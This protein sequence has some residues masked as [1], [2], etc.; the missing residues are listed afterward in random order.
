M[1]SPLPSSALLS[2]L[3]LAGCT[4]GPRFT[5]PHSDTPAGWSA[6]ALAAVPGRAPGSPVAATPITE[7]EWWRSFGDPTLSSLIEQAA[8][9]SLDVREAVLRIAEAR[10]QRD[11]TAAGLWPDLSGNASYVRERISEKMAFTSL[12]GSAGSTTP[13]RPPQGGISG[14]IPGF[15][16]P[17]SAYQYGFDA[18]WELDLFGRTR[19]AVEAAG[20]D[21]DAALESGRDVLLSVLAEIARSYVD[22]RAA[23]LRL[24][25]LEDSLRTE[26]DTLQL[27]R[28]RRT[29]GL[30][31][32]LDVERAAAQVTSTESQLPLAR[33]RITTDINQ[34]SFLLGREP[35]ALRAE[36]ERTAP[37]PAVPP[38]V[39]IGLPAEVIRRRPDIRLAEAQLHAATARVGVAVADL[40]PR[41]TLNA[42]VG[43]QAEHPQD[44]TNWASR[45]FSVGPA[46]ELPIFSGG[47]RQATV[48]L[49]NVRT[50]E[51]AVAYARTV[52]AAIHEVENALV[53]Y[54]PEQSRRASLDATVA[55]NREALLLA[56]QRYESGV[57]SFLDVLEAERNLQQSQLQLADSTAAVAIDLIALYKALGGGWSSPE[58]AASPPQDPGRGAIPP[59]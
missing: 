47:R 26:R 25:I 55:H 15:V 9:S 44:L 51:A 17:F 58:L 41:L 3:L 20:A 33:S 32:D 42:A 46:L 56:R 57:T 19:R 59:P 50:K 1:R 5:P 27:T 35:G 22:L 12:L 21:S 48:R 18:S 49:Q 4:V 23:Q 43:M 11:I 24:A 29:V 36:L 53:L 54:G 31:N 45:F 34:L 6:E 13:G 7:A 40:F 39:P 38:Q 16:N 2:G 37:V 10:A 28:D 30:G 14:P 8:G 52:L